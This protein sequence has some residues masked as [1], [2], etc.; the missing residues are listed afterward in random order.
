[1]GESDPDVLLAL[2]LA[3]RAPR[4]GHICI[5]LAQ[6]DTFAWQPESPREESA[7]EPLPWPDKNAWIAKVAASP[8]VRGAGQDRVTP[9]VLDGTILYS[10]RYFTY[11]SRLAQALRARAMQTQPIR[12]SV[13]LRRGLE[14]LFRSGAGE[15]FDRQRLGAAM[16]LLGG[17]TVISGGPGTGKTH[18]IRAVLALAWAQWAV[19]HDPQRDGPGPLVALAA[20]TG[21]AAARMR[22][23]L[24]AGLEA[25][26]QQTGS[27]LPKRRNPEQLQVFMESLQPCTI[28]RLLGYNPE[29]PTRFR[30]DAQWP[31]AHEMVIIDESSMVD[32]ALMT[33]LV[34]AVS[35]QARLVLLGDRYQL[36][37]VEAGTVL[38]DICGPS[39]VKRMGISEDRVGELATYSGIDV[40]EQPFLERK[41]ERGIQDAIVLFEKNWRFDPSSGMGSFAKACLDELVEPSQV[42]DILMKFCDS[43]VAEQASSASKAIPET[44]RKVIVEGYRPYLER[45]LAGPKGNESLAAFHAAVLELFGSFRILC[46]HRDGRWGVTGMNREVIRLLEESSEQTP[47]QRFDPSRVYWVGRPVMILRND[48]IVQRFNGDVGIVVKDEKG[49]TTVVFPEVGGVSYIAPSRLPEHQTVFAMT[50]HKS[51]G[52]EFD[53][54]LVVLPDRDSRILTKEL[55]Y[56]AVTRAKHT[57]TMMAQ[58]QV[59]VEA[60]GRTIR[61]AS[62]LEAKLWETG[63]GSA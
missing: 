15:A 39:T 37:S 2:A 50:I 27:L 49:K 63:K 47:L 4:H 23:A 19:D 59:L 1:V 12:D 56:T 16:A 18:T 10:D 54:C 20:P 28:H 41:G 30:H 43:E 14:A 33:K 6:M 5:D 26:V 17:L 7:L 29:R 9:F 35:P 58:R 51:Q 48:A 55:V 36:A 31:L 8:L 22:E 13:G 40:A 11:Q 53:H 34:D 57:I 38:A 25:F 21:K 60:L 46:A 24:G 44:I 3:V 45:L 52:S 62:G 61:R 42:A 32:L